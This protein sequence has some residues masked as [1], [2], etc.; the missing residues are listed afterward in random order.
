M[1]AAVASLILLLI[2]ALI[3]DGVFV[4]PDDDAMPSAGLTRRLRPLLL[5]GYIEHG[6]FADLMGM[7]SQV[8]E[9]SEMQGE[10]RRRPS[11]RQR[12]ESFLY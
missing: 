7:L 5:L 12:T 2:V 11:S 1:W 4:P 10:R 3:L 9:S 8:S 6:F